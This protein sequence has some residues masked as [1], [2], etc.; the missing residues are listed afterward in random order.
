MEFGSHSVPEN[1][2]SHHVRDIVRGARPTQFY[3]IETLVVG[4]SHTFDHLPGPQLPSTWTS[5]LSMPPKNSNSAERRTR[6]S[7]RGRSPPRG[8]STAT[9]NP[10]NNH[11]QPVDRLSPEQGKELPSEDVN[12]VGSPG[13]STPHTDVLSPGG[14]GTSLMDKSTNVITSTKSM[15]ISDSPISALETETETTTAVVLG[16]NE[17]SSSGSNED[18]KDPPAPPSTSDK[19]LNLVLAELKEIKATMSSIHKIDK[20]EETTESI[21]RELSGISDRTSELEEVF[22]A[23][24]ARIRELG[25][26]I[27][28]LKTA[29]QKQVKSITALQKM[30]EEVSQITNKKVREMNELIDNQ[31]EQVETFQATAEKIEQN[32]EQNLAVEMDKKIEKKFQQLAQESHF[33]SL[34]EQA[35]DK[36]SNLIITGL[37]EDEQKS[38]HDLVTDHL[39]NT[40]GI[41]DVVVKAAYRLGPTPTDQS[42]YDRPILVKFN[43]LQQRNRIWKKRQ[44]ITGENDN[45]KI[46][47]QADLPKELREGIQMLYRVAKAAAKMDQFQS[48]RVFNYQLEIDGKLYQPSQLEDLPNEIRPSTLA[49]PRSES[50]LAFFS[51]NS[52]LSNHFPSEFTVKE[53]KFYTV[54]HYLAVKRAAFSDNPSMIQKASTARDP[55]QAKYIL[56][57]LKEDRPQEWYGGVQEVLLEGLRAKFKQNPTL[58]SFLLDTGGLQ[59]GEASTDTRW[60]IGMTLDDPEVLNLTKWNPEGNLLGRTLMQIREELKQDTTPA[61]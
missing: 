35:Y 10:H 17:H 2:T 59:L 18:L 37:P 36:R 33:Q 19:V 52:I 16:D 20:I 15:P 14:E 13:I 42:A 23:A 46:R 47:I 21:S 25:D 41:K 51:K 54:E 28:T 61:N 24:S 22:A 29:A 4:I 55:R 12:K 11:L 49:T 40:L 43:N 60:G 45:R 30:K 48:A 34:R 39:G 8:P 31:R 38:T 58:R 1:L 44:T 26:D 3:L 32:I 57:S 6:N 53:Q 7:S 50:S 5:I 9:P 27:S 56:N